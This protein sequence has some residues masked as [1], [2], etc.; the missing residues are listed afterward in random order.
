MRHFVKLACCLLLAA[1]QAAAPERS[2]SDRFNEIRSRPPELA[3]F[4][5][6][7]PKGGDLHNHLSGAIYAES[8]IAWASAASPPLCINL[9]KWM[10]E[11]P[12]CD[13][14]KRRPSVPEYAALPDQRARLINAFSMR[15]YV[16]GHET[17]S[18]HDQFFVTFS[19]FSA[20]G[21]GRIGDML[22]EVSVRAAQQNINYLE[23]MVSFRGRDTRALAERVG[24]D[25]SAASTRTKLLQAGMGQQIAP[26]KADLDDMERAR[27]RVLGCD[28]QPN[29]AACN[30]TIRYIAQIIRTLPMQYV[31]A[32]TLFAFELIHADPR[33]VGLN[34]VAPEDYAVALAD[35]EKHMLLLRDLA[36]LVP[37]T[38]LT[39]H[40]GELAMGLVPPENLRSHIRQ[41]VLV[42]GARRIGHGVA[43]AHE[44]DAA[45]LLRAM[46]ERNV[47]VEINLTSNDVILGVRGKQHP[48]ELYRRAG[49]PVALSTDDEGVSRIDLTHEYQRA[50]ET[51]DLSYA[52]IKGLARNSLAYSFLPGENLWS[53]RKHTTVVTAC[54]G[55]ML[56]SATPPPPCAEF[57]ARS[58]KA[59]QQ[60]RLEGEFAKFEAAVTGTQ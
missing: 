9:E 22:A 36:A 43:I 24:W 26:A 18:A 58:E 38:P 56:G 53:D 35:Y 19:R 49:V 28:T 23:L 37:D 52:D 10:L 16:P 54:A 11:A 33:V 3:I 14:A 40:A 4:L 27:R 59:R 2:V 42:A 21:E 7:M 5:R 25:G 12:P 6:Q 15:D 50:V 44:D 1:C 13:T 32:Q 30:V 47:L 60:W 8:Y 45:D 46:R 20:A 55:T 39:L 17:P 48:F 51:Y 34:Y 57:L 31:V 29:L 41:A